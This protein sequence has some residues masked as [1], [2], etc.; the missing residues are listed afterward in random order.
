MR[1]ICRTQERRQRCG[2]PGSVRVCT[3][4][5]DRSDARAAVVRGGEGS[6][7]D[8]DECA[9]PYDL[10]AAYAALDNN[11]PMPIARDV[12]SPSTVCMPLAENSKSLPDDEVPCSTPERKT[13]LQEPGSSQKKVA[14]NCDR[15]SEDKLINVAVMLEDSQA[16]ADSVVKEA[17]KTQFANKASKLLQNLAAHCAKDE[18]QAA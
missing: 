3:H 18:E 4:C 9:W 11:G 13:L 2:G 15:A 16:C 10:E 6:G 5:G 1:A 8:A 14:L 7:G 17:V 12:M